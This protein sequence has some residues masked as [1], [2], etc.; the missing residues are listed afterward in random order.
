ELSFFSPIHDRQLPDADSLYLPGGY[1]ELHHQAL[2][3]NTAMLD[4]IR[5]HHA[6]GKPLLAECGG[7]LYLLDS[8]TDVDGIRAELV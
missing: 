8:L 4:A 2:S 5:A 3:E 6:A 1:P 7:M